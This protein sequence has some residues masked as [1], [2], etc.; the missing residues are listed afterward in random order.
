MNP[1]APLWILM[2]ALDYYS[3][4]NSQVNK[5]SNICYNLA[6]M[7]QHKCYWP[8]PTLSWSYHD[9]I[10]VSLSWYPR[11]ALT[12]TEGRNNIITCMRETS[13]AWLQQAAQK[14]KQLLKV[15]MVQTSSW[16]LSLGECWVVNSQISRRFSLK[17]IRTISGYF[18][19]QQLAAAAEWPAARQADV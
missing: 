8:L 19:K 18:F 15:D 14:C 10:S 4:W 7:L 6:H 5:Q 1:H 3:D 2:C 13:G 12:M 16:R 9:I 17:L 11:Q